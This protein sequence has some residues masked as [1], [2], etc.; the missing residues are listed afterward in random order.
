MAAA[1]GRP[2]PEEIYAFMRATVFADETTDQTVSMLED[3]L[4]DLEEIACA[5]W[6]RRIFLARRLRR[7]IR[8]SIRGVE[9]QDFADRRVSAISY[10]LAAKER[11]PGG[12][13]DGAL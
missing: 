2:A 11:R 13:Q 9:G 3:R 6:P 1:E 12:R 8:A 7:K 5:G 10:E 4:M